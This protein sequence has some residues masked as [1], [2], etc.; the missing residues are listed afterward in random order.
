MF[1]Y[2]EAR[3]LANYCMYSTNFDEY[4][5]ESHFSF[6]M[7]TYAKYYWEEKWEKHFGKSPEEMKREKSKGKAKDVHLGVTIQAQ[8]N[9][10][11]SHDVN[12]N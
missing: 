7:H 1:F 12:A 4:L 10:G 6:T 11:T 3:V 2:F 9:V 5:N 8:A